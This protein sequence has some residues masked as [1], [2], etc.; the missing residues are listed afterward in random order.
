MMQNK[1]KRA[2]LTDL[3]P[4]WSSVE[5][6]L[7]TTSA[8]KVAERKKR[9]VPVPV[10]SAP[11]ERAFLPSIIPHSRTEYYSE[12][13]TRSFM[14]TKVSGAPYGQYLHHNQL[15]VLTGKRA[16]AFGPSKVEDTRCIGEFLNGS[17]EFIHKNR[18]LWLRSCRF[19]LTITTLNYGQ[20][21][22]NSDRLRFRFLLIVAREDINLRPAWEFWEPTGNVVKCDLQQEWVASN[23][24]LTKGRD[25]DH[26]S[27]DDRHY[28]NRDNNY[29]HLDGGNFQMIAPVDLS[30]WNVLK[31]S[32]Y[33]MG[34]VMRGAMPNSN[35]LSKIVF[36]LSVEVELNDVV[37]FN[38]D[39]LIVKGRRIFGVLCNQTNYYNGMR[40]PGTDQDM[41]V[42]CHMVTGFQYLSTGNLNNY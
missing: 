16:T 12:L 4:V 14:C 22:Y 8:S 13:F 9:K 35:G 28:E 24:F 38:K 6:V 26:L 19:D 41:F 18:S 15:V 23:V 3:V 30:K 32:V 11:R 29:A 36:P 34:Q 17:Y 25:E 21:W 39:G 1:R 10:V 2:T 27:Y 20:T 5:D 7:A 42:F 40:G 31:D 33:D 37:T